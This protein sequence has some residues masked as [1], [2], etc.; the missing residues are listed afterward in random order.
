[1]A[2]TT[3]APIHNELAHLYM[4]AIL[5]PGAPVD[6]GRRMQDFLCRCQY[7]D[8]PALLQ[9][10]PAD[11]GDLLASERAVVLHRLG[12]SDEVR[13]QHGVAWCVVRLSGPP[14][15]SRAR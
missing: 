12:R 4:S 14:G 8:L 2:G 3:L 15:A 5:Q 7:V 10:M 13:V 9:D 6:A 1:M 11:K